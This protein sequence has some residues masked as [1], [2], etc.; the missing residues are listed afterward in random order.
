MVEVP[1]LH[2]AGGAGLVSAALAA[3]LSA[4]WLPLLVLFALGERAVPAGTAGTSPQT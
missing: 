4:L 3:T 1:E 2:Q